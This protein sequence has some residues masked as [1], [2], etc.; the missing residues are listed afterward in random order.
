MVLESKRSINIL[1]CTLR[2]GSYAVDFKFTAEDT[3]LICGL[4]S[5]V[6]FR[7]IEV[8]HGVGLGAS[9]AG[10]GQAASSDAAVIGEAK[11]KAGLAK[12]GAFYIPG[13]GT[14][15]DLRRAA[16]A[17]L[18]FVRVGFNADETEKALGDVAAARRCG[19][20]T[21]LNFMKTYG[22]S[23]ASFAERC[24]RAK[25]AGAQV[26][27]IVDSAGGMLPDEVASYVAAARESEDLPVGFH[28]HSNLHLAVA[29]SL[30]A[31]RS[32]ATFIDTSLY[33]IG[34]SSG[35][36]PSEVLVAVLDRMGIETGVDLFGVMEIADR[37]LRPVMEQIHLH[38]M[39]AV[40]LGY[41]RFHSSFLPQVQQA[42]AAHG[43]DLYRLVVAL[44][45]RDPMRVTDDLL[46][47]VIRDLPPV[48]P[49]Q[50]QPDPPLGTFSAPRFGRYSIRNSPTAVIEL[51]GG[52]TTVA[53]KSRLR[54]VLDLSAFAST[55]KHGQLLAEFVLQDNFMALGRIR[56][57]SLEVV[58]DALKACRDRVNTFLLD[59]CQVGTPARDELAERI[60]TVV[61]GATVIPYDSDELEAWS[62]AQTLWQLSGQPSARVALLWE[63]GWDSLQATSFPLLLRLAWLFET[64]I[65]PNALDITRRLA[66]PGRG[67]IVGLE[68]AESGITGCDPVDV[69]VMRGV[70]SEEKLLRL[71][72][73]VRNGAWV[74]CAGLAPHER[75]AEFAET[76]GWRLLFLPRDEMYRGQLPRWMATLTWVESAADLL[77]PR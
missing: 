66:G 70:P 45:Q 51:V 23:P 69:V 9:A 27:Y 31:C 75:L 52:L 29:N 64:V 16:D 13:V 55:N 22:I 19:L 11:K 3:G 47:E 74:V 28:G 32:G 30:A 20:M 14:R 4:L 67:H 7:Y 44:G 48:V 10:K 6:G 77:I 40:A 50:D 60:S 53:A 58:G 15:D 5:G 39:L 36:T 62:L 26:V 21:C 57:D 49:R 68:I 25:E 37:C 46:A 72:P 59:L 43:V 63:E 38:D 33:G 1:D 24:R 61:P 34:R 8:G 41:G 76:Q 54:P 42:A 35:N 71:G 18:D 12:I 73:L 56:Y 17:G 65:V 2:D